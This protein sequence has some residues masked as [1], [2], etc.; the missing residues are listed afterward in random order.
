MIFFWLSAA[1][2][3]AV[4]LAFVLPPLFGRKHPQALSRTQLN[5]AAYRDQLEELEAARVNG[6]I[7]ETAFAEARAELERGLLNDVGAS[8]PDSESR[9]TRRIS[10]PLAAVVVAVAI[11]LLAFGLYLSLG[12]PSVLINGVTSRAE[13]PAQGSS[14]SIEEM[15]AS[16]EQRLKKQ[17]NDV[18]GW[19]MLG[20]SYTFMQ[21]F[22]EAGAAYA[23]AYALAPDEPAV[24]VSYAEVLTRIGQGRVPD[25]AS[26]MLDKA[27]AANPDL[28]PAL[29]LAG[30]AAFQRGDNATAL[31]RWKRVREIG[32]LKP[33]TEKVLARFIARAEGK[34]AEAAPAQTASAPA[35][36]SQPA[37]AGGAKLLVHVSLSPELATKARPD[38]LVFIYARAAKGPP[39]PLAAVRRKVRDLPLTV[40][41]DDG[42][43]MLPQMRLSKF[44]EVVVGARI[45]KSG[46][47][48]PSS[49]DLQGL[50][51][52]VRVAEAGVVEVSIGQVVP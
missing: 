24:L 34:P 21:R 12:T 31:K 37:A 13:G 48:T 23:R 32:G 52:P 43:A 50:S 7:D 51:E 17:P 19:L 25:Q 2:L 42:M 27:L 36:A 38:E 28:Q 16:L 35:A 33:A 9:S 6:I 40:T 22:K 11:P 44:P 30:M 8:E 5:T 26:A 3:I 18:Q 4:T 49:G 46:A 14:P 47:P 41:L 39:M 45:S 1:V 20:R 15:V 10:H 29:W